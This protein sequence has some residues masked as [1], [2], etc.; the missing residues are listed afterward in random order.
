MHKQLRITALLLVF[1]MFMSIMAPFANVKAASEYETKIAAAQTE[2]NKAKTKLTE[3][4]K[5]AATAKTAY[6][7]A[8]PSAKEASLIGFLSDSKY[9]M[10][11]SGTEAHIE[12]LREDS[13]GTPNFDDCM[14]YTDIGAELDATSLDGL[15][16]SLELFEEGNTLRNQEG[17][18]S[19]KIS[20]RAM[21][22]AAIECNYYFYNN[23]HLY[24]VGTCGSN[25][26]RYYYDP[27][28][29]WYTKEKNNYINGSGSTG[30]YLTMISKYYTYGGF[31]TRYAISSSGQGLPAQSIYCQTFD[32]DTTN[33]VIMDVATVK[34]KAK[35]YI[36]YI[37]SI[38]ATE[39]S[40]YEKAQAAVT[41]QEKVVSEKEEAL[42][43]L[44]P[45]SVSLNY[46]A[47]SITV[48]STLNITATVK[49]STA[50]SAVTWTSSDST[51]ATVSNGT[52]K[53]IKPGTAKITAKTANGKTET[54]TIT[55]KA[56]S[57]SSSSSSGSSSSSNS[58]TTKAV[59][60]LYNPS[61]NE[62]LYTTDANEYDTL[63][64]KHGWGK[65]GIGW[66]A[67][68]SGTAI[69]RLYQPGLDNHLYTTDQ[70]EIKVLTSK[71]GWIP[72]NDSKPVFYS[73]G[74]VSIYRVYNKGLNGMHH[75]TTDVNEYNTLPK[76]GWQQEGIKL[77][78]AKV[79][80]PLKTTNYYNYY[81]K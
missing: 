48:G 13:M 36:N 17:A 9:G 32:E 80:N 41:A 74:S 15:L 45:T 62:H 38:G 40:A 56:A 37:N 21:L 64:R 78:A 20:A 79:G 72:D 59:Y 42:T 24:F 14:K 34:T 63:W 26:A 25:L 5:T 66:Y 29:A 19:L 3:L 71:Y 7:K 47:W 68:S 43:A 77:H 33:T 8:K 81:K 55:V 53:G 1:L 60:R 6:E 75:L 73:G 4:Q 46:L 12:A 27:Y 44:Q 61:T 65:E 70:N 28:D 10:G 49:P 23:D 50:Y 67:P 2:L 18:S 76:Y 52:I 57:S 69:Y 11:W 16:F 39:R 35:N 30:H 51:V 31:A 58:S 54:C 22:E